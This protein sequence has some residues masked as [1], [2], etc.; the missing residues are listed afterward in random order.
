[1][2]PKLSFPFPSEELVSPNADLEL[3]QLAF[4][5]EVAQVRMEVGAGASHGQAEVRVQQLSLV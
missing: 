2:L 3:L 4:S 1:L 5:V